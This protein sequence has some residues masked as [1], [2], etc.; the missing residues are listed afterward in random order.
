[1][2]VTSDGRPIAKSLR[3]SGLANLQERAERRGGTMTLSTVDG[4]TV[5]VWTAALRHPP[6]SDGT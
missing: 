2:T 1:V 5:L 6:Q 3:R 4:R